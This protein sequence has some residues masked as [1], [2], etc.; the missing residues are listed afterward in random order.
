MNLPSEATLQVCSDC[1]TELGPALLS[2]PRCR[3]LVH[4][5]TLKDL[6]ERAESAAASGDAQAALASWRSSLELLP[7][8]SRQSAAVAQRIAALGTTVDAALSAPVE[9][10]TSGRWKWLAAL[11][12]AGLLIWKFKFLVVALLTKGK[13]LLLGLSKAGTLASMFASMGLY[14]T[15]WGLWFALGLVLSIYVHEMGH[16]AAIRR[17][18]IAATAPMFIPGFGALIRLKQAPV[19]PR[20][21]ARIGLAGPVWGLGASVA[22]ALAGQIASS[23]LAMA[24]A[25]TG[26]WINILNL[27]PVWQLDG[28]R[29]FA[30]LTRLHRWIA[31]AALALAWL[32]TRDGAVL[33]VLLVAVGRT[34]LT[35]ADAPPDRGALILFVFVT[36]A[37]AVIWRL[38]AVSSQLSALSYQLSAIS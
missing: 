25:H 7:P 23:P 18:G 12:P 13:F 20:E 6:A 15:Q 21:N 35:P 1:G 19:T 34:A 37:L 24:I 38:T 2:C 4:A 8:D 3:R 16:V 10:P 9:V 32:L 30:S 17:Y 36:L 14:W 5:S 11:G 28:S 27:A 22:A 29:G 26:A 33:I 31:T